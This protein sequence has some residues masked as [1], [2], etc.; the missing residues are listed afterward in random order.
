MK[1]I[2]MARFSHLF[3]IFVFGFFIGG[4]KTTEIP[5]EQSDRM[6]TSEG[7]YSL[8]LKSHPKTDWSNIHFSSKTLLYKN[9]ELAQQSF[10]KTKL[11]L[12][13]ETR[14]EGKDAPL[15]VRNTTVEK[16][17][18]RNLHALG[19]PEKGETI[20]LKLDPS[21]RVLEVEGMSKQS[22]F[23]VPPVLL[24]TH[25]VNFGDKWRETFLWEGEGIGGTLKTTIECQLSGLQYWKSKK[26]F[27]IEMKALSHLEDDQEFELS[28]HSRGY[29]LWDNEKG[30]V[31]YAKAMSKD[32][33]IP[34]NGNDKIVTI[35]KLQLNHLTSK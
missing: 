15:L 6:P 9:N 3:L 34:K 25:K 19:F 11:K 31:I 4:C 7:R 28:S 18:D 24:P 17:G 35:S 1:N 2:S 29:M 5:L 13:S 23:Y 12:K 14:G 27:R 22:I 16:W 33:L 32:T 21:G 8:R 10:K 30:V 26:V 20:A